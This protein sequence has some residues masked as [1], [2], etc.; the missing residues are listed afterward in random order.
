MP[1]YETDVFS[2][3]QGQVGGQCGLG[4]EPER[5]SRTQGLVMSQEEQREARQCQ[6]P[7][8]SPPTPIVPAMDNDRYQLIEKKDNKEIVN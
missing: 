6:T 7:H 3:F 8:F 4:W 1:Q 2:T 5:Y